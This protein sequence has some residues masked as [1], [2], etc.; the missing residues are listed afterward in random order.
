MLNLKV[1]RFINSIFISNSYILF[2]EENENAYVID[3]GD[4][5]PL[6]DWLI[7][8]NK[9]LNGIFL[10]HSHFDHI[11]GINDL[12]EKYPNINMHAS[13]F[14]KEG[15]LS[16]KLNGSRYTEMPF[17]VDSP[18]VNIVKE[19]DNIHLWKNIQLNVIETPGH[20]RDCISL[21]IG[22]NLFTGD[23]L[24]PGIKVVAKSKYSDKVQAEI[25]TRRILSKFNDN[26]M[27]WPGHNDK[28]LLG[29]IKKIHTI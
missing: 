2:T 14:A 6:I 29:E 25:S 11:Y 12:I 15:F 28:C 17:V 27:I 3:P 19:G 22:E 4:S 24:I 16:E 26:T 9:V 5:K 10:T 18:N 7:K 20:N 8:S 23:A 21:L 1:E 13:F